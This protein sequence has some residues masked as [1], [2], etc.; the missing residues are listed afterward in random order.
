VVIKSP[1]CTYPPTGV[2]FKCLILSDNYFCQND[3]LCSWGIS[4]ALPKKIKN[5][6][7]WVLFIKFSGTSALLG[8]YGVLTNAAPNEEQHGFEAEGTHCG[9]SQRSRTLSR[10]IGRQA[11][12]AA[13][14]ECTFYCGAG[15]LASG[16]EVDAVERGGGGITRNTCPLPP[17]GSSTRTWLTVVM[18]DVL[19]PTA[20]MLD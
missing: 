3:G 6:Q 16:T 8:N 11:E 14:R 5:G 20:S 9:P 12:P 13:L 2:E 19:L 1:A 18:V 10:K 4:Y 17:G 7:P 15:A